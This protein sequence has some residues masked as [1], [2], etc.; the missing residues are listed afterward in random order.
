M[1]VRIG[2]MISG[3]VLAKDVSSCCLLKWIPSSLSSADL[4]KNCLLRIFVHMKVRMVR[5]YL[6]F[7]CVSTEV[8]GAV[9]DSL[10]RFLFSFVLS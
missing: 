4:P 3:T 2:W 5:A 9:M 6:V 8:S 7:S 1:A 10:F